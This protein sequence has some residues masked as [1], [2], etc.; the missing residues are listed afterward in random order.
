MA[1]TIGERPEATA[2]NKLNKLKSCVI[3]LEKFINNGVMRWG[4]GADYGSV[5]FCE[6]GDPIDPGWKVREDVSWCFDESV[7]ESS[8]EF[9][10]FS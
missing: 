9:S 7:S 10:F 6:D 4:G 2:K 3:P 5:R 8:S 1:L